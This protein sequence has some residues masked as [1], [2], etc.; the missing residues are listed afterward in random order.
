MVNA[1]VHCLQR[2]YAHIDL[3]K[4]K[5][6]MQSKII[7]FIVNVE[8]WQNMPPQNM[9]LQHND[10]FEQ[11]ILEKQQIQKI[12]LISPLSSCKQEIKLACER[13]PPYTR[14]KEACL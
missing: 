2:K 7:N 13:C 10:Y 1:F 14:K 4:T 6:N 8:Q 9:S 11:K 5:L 3:L 12:I